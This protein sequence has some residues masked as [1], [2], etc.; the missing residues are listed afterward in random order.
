M[1]D[2]FKY[3]GFLELRKSCFLYIQL[4]KMVDATEMPLYYMHIVIGICDLY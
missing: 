3:K 1:C 2:I 4:S